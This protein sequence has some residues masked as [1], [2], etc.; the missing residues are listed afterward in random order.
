[1][2]IERALLYAN[3]VV[4]GDELTTWEVRKQCE[5]FLN[6]YNNEDDTYY[7]DVDEV[8][9][10]EDLLSVMNFATGIGCIGKSI[11]EGLHGFQCFFI[12]NI[13]GFRHKNNPKKF[14]HPDVPLFIPRKNAQ[15]L[16]FSLEIVKIMIGQNR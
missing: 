1:M 8:K 13:F 5:I 3:M 14:K 4:A 15:I 2:L 10:I 9:I 16:V 11:L 7:F 6:D 12:V